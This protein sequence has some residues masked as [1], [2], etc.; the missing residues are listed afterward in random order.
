[1]YNITPEKIELAK[2]FV[3]EKWKQRATELGRFEPTDLSFSCK[4]SSLFIQG[5]FGGIIEGN[6][7]H[8]YNVINGETVDINATASDVLEL[9]DPYYHDIEFF[10]NWHHRESME[11]CKPRVNGWITEFIETYGIYLND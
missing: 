9:D 6:Y 11:S 3:F 4:F 5:L 2:H 1:M 8:Q 10:G 7:Y